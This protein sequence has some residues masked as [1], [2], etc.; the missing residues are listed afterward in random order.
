MCR[1]H[2]LFGLPVSPVARRQDRDDVLFTLEDG[3]GRVA[4]V[5]LTYKNETEPLWPR[6]SFFPDLD[7]WLQVMKSDHDEFCD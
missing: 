3:S 5:H 4:V 1:G 2:V 7:S 6:T